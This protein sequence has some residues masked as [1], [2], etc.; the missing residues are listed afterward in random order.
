MFKR[1]STGYKLASPGLILALICFFLP[2]VMQSCGDQPLQEYTGLQLA[3]GN[4]GG[5]N[6]Y[7]GNPFVLLTLI[8]IF[9]VLFFAIRYTRHGSLGIRDTWGVLITSLLTLLFLFQQYLTTPDEG[10]NREVLP[11]LW[12]YVA[13]WLFVLIGGV[14][15]TVERNR[16]Q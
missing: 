5:D 13:G 9:V 2:W 6:G 4:G 15:N 16:K 1:L 14:V 10:V 12:G 11:G 3:I 8:A 7:N